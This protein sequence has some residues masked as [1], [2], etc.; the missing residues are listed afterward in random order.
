MMGDLERPTEA[1]E[2]GR[3][4]PARLVGERCA[5]VEAGGQPPVE[6]AQ[7]RMQT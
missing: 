6:A 7:V 2:A 5:G 1:L 3:L 4:W